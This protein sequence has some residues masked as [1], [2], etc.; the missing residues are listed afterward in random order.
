MYHN[1]RAQEK[2]V[3]GGWHGKCMSVFINK[4]WRC[5][6]VHMWLV[7]C[8]ET[9]ATLREC[10]QRM[11]TSIFSA[12]KFD[13]ILSILLYFIYNSGIFKRQTFILSITT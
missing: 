2:H 7:Y 8:P 13:Y 11:L 4:I 3:N 5:M 12:R 10:A 1:P 9:V 6:L